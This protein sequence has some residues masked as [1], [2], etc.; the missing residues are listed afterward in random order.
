VVSGGMGPDLDHIETGPDVG[1]PAGVGLEL[2]R[3][4]P[5]EPV[6]AEEV[7]AVE[8]VAVEVAA[9]EAADA[10]ETVSAEGPTTDSEPTDAVG[11]LFDRIRDG[12][13]RAVDKAR[14]V[15]DEPPAPAEMEGAP[16]EADVAVAEPAATESAATGPAASRHHE[17]PDAGVTHSDADEARLQQREVVLADLER[18][19][20]RRLKRTLQDEQNDLLDRLRGVKGAPGLHDLLLPVEAHTEPYRAAARPILAK[21]A[22]AGF[23]LGLEWRGEAPSRQG[24]AGPEAR[25]ADAQTADAQ[26]RL[27][28]ERIV[29]PLR[30]QIE[31][32]FADQGE[33]GPERLTESLGSVYRSTRAQRV[34]RVAAD[35]ISS[36]FAAGT[37]QATPA[38]ATLRWIAEDADGPCPD[39]DD[40]ALAGILVKGEAFPTGQLYPPAHDGC[41]CLLVPEA[42]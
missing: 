12:R 33:D 1:P 16:L 13:K 18:D 39:C 6:V 32:M 11:S 23:D 3:D 15:L 22:A 24:D 28:A 14:Q 19:L 31:K 21:A 5:E 10:E 27:V 40:N 29:D 7:V 42:P 30:R 36:T 41:R 4:I 34:E 38:G 9:E 25:T 20:N 26:A 37:W 2:V 8:V 17:D 35:V